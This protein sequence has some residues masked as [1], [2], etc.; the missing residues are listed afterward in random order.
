[1]RMDASIPSDSVAAKGIQWC[2]IV[3][4]VDDYGMGQVRVRN[5]NM[6]DQQTPA[7][8][9]DSDFWLMQYA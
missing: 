8:L 3:H 4:I 1:M 9:A 5:Q 2:R 6:S 7:D